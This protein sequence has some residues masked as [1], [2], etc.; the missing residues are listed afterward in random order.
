MDV[1]TMKKAVDDVATAEMATTGK[2]TTDV[3]ATKMA[4]DDAVVVEMATAEV[5][6]QRE[7]ESSPALV[8]GAK[9][10]AVSGSSTCPAKRPF[11]GPWRP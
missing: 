6:T 3:V 10:A 5:A 11:C 9:R 2:R 7:A 8:V 1:A 4:V